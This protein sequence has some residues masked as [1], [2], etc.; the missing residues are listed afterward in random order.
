MEKKQCADACGPYKGIS[1]NGDCLRT[2]H[3]P[4]RSYQRRSTGS[5]DEY[6]S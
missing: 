4:T 5:D 6:M 1:V 2:L 3:T